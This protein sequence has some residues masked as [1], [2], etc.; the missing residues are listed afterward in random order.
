MATNNVLESSPG[1][2]WQRR[3]ADPAVKRVYVIESSCYSVV[4]KVKH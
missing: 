1:L 2:P 4:E 3:V